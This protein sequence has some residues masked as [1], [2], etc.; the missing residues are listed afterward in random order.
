M[1]K[2]I[3]KFIKER[4][5]QA[6]LTGKWEHGG[7][8]SAPKIVVLHEKTA[9]DRFF[10]PNQKKQNNV[11]ARRYCYLQLMV[12]VQKFY[13]NESYIICYLQEAVLFYS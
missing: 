4:G 2:C 1:F 7:V 11:A 12:Q 13:L 10:E 5:L 3:E 6:C 8:V 9:I